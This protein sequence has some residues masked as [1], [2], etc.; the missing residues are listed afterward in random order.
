MQPLPVN[1]PHILL[2]LFSGDP[3]PGF[4]YSWEDECPVYLPQPGELAPLPDEAMEAAGWGTD[5][6]GRV[7]QVYAADHLPPHLTGVVEPAPFCQAIVELRTI[8][9]EVSPDGFVALG[10][11]EPGDAK[12]LLPLLEEHG[13]TFEIQADHSALL[14]PGRAA[15]LYLGF[16]PQGSALEVWVSAEQLAHVRKLL[17][18]LYPPEKAPASVPELAAVMPAGGAAV[19]NYAAP[20]TSIS[21]RARGEFMTD[22]D[23]K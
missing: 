13:V 10:S 7:E 16:A 20:A 5:Y 19:E 22:P 21:A 4:L 17:R 2:V 1:E 11:F 9:P 6:A 23:G 15:S 12:V 8:S 14:Q 18:F 3:E